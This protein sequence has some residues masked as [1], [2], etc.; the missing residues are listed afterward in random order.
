MFIQELLA[1]LADHIRASNWQ[2]CTDSFAGWS[3]RL[4]SANPVSIIIPVYNGASDVERLLASEDL[5][6]SA[7][8]VLLID[9]HSSDDRISEILSAVEYSQ[10]KVRVLRNSRN[11]G[12]VRTVNIGILERRYG[13]DVLIL[14][15]DALPEGDWLERLRCVAYARPNVATVSPLSNSAGFYSLPTPNHLNEVPDRLAPQACAQLLGWLAPALYEETVATSG[16]CWYVRQDALEQVGVLD[17]RLFHR[18]YAEETD[19]CLRAAEHGFL[20]LC[21]LTGYVAHGMA[22]SFKGEKEMLKKNNANILKAINPQFID[23]L[24]RYE[25]HSVLHELGKDF[26]RYSSELMMEKSHAHPESGYEQMSSNELTVGLE[27]DQV[28]LDFGYNSERLGTDVSSIDDLQFYLSARLRPRKICFG[29]TVGNGGA[30][31]RLEA[32]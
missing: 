7:S 12:F 3:Q 5:W 18:G 31:T 1:R 25:E 17:D 27:R 29:N 30:S 6:Q 22:Q 9:D 23:Q 8:E 16:F 14:N 32:L 24:R 10:D 4:A 15:S 20:N 26:D 21:C 2:A 28:V 19:F 13:N 11:L